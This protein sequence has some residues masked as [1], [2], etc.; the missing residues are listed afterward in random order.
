LGGEENVV[1]ADLW[2]LL[3]G[4]LLNGSLGST[5]NFEVFGEDVAVKSGDFVSHR[6]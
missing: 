1:D 4:L 6:G 3:N 5:V 2:L